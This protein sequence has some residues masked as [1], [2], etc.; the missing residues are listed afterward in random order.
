MKYEKVSGFSDEIASDINTQFKVLKKLGIK[1]FEPR[2]VD[3]KNISELSEEEAEK[4]YEKARSCGILASQ[5][6]SPIGKIK[7]GEDFGPHFKKFCNTV[8]IAKILK[9]KYIRIFSFFGS[10]EGA[11]REKE[12]KEVLLRLEKMIDYAAAEGVVLLHENEKDIFGEKAAE[13]L[14]LMEKLSCDNFGAVFDPA[15]FVQVGQDTKEAF[16]MLKPYIK[17]VHI[18]DAVSDTGAVVPAGMGNGN[19]E[20]ILKDLFCGG[21]DGFLS[22]EPHLGSFV[23]LENLE[24]GDAMKNIPSGGEGAFTVAANALDKILEGIM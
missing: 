20:Y 2:G 22:L 12:R 15:N 18:K 23:G 9:T 11:F 14:Y 13:C 8:R 3:G 6:G 19:V 7:I 4:L 1:Y 10:G 17:Y 16:S 5:I 24:I 21:F